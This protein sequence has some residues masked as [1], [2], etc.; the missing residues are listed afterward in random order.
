MRTSQILK[1]GS[2]SKDLFK[3]LDLLLNMIQ[4]T[5]YCLIYLKFI[6]LF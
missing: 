2:F 4:E 1:T 6:Y 5:D 3:N